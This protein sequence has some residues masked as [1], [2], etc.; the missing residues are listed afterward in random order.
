MSGDAPRELRRAVVAVVH[1]KPARVVV[2]YRPARQLPQVTGLFA[3]ARQPFGGSAQV[4]LETTYPASV[5]S[6]MP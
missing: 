6:V 4:G 1:A 5:L 3:Q 2:G